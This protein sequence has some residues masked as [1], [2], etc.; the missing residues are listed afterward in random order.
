MRPSLFL[1]N[2]LNM[3]SLLNHIRYLLGLPRKRTKE[4]VRR[5]E[6]LRKAVAFGEVGSITAKTIHMGTIPNPFKKS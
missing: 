5:L 4:D 6:D 3:T 2:L 1:A